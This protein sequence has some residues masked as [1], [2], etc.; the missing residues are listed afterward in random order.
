MTSRVVLRAV[1]EEDLPA[2]FEQQR[3]PAS[4]AMAGVPGRDREAFDAHWERLL[5]LYRRNLV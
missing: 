4:V 5:A 3:D 2:I 1:R